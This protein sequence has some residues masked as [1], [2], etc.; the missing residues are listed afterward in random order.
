MTYR[1]DAGSH[2]ESYDD[3]LDALPAARMVRRLGATH[4]RVWRTS[5]GALLSAVT[6][7]RDNR[8]QPRDVAMPGEP[9]DRVCLEDRAQRG[10]LS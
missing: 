4:V 10:L 5:D 2:E 8:W 9:E 1:D 3:V 6:V 7:P